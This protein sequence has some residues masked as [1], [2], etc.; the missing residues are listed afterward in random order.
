MTTAT[1]D[2]LIKIRDLLHEAGWDAPPPAP[3]VGP[4]LDAV[5]EAFAQTARREDLAVLD[6]ALTGPAEPAAVA[7]AI[8]RLRRFAERAEGLIPASGS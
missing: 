6:A 7:A 2:A 8:G 4:P 5:R 1:R 3:T